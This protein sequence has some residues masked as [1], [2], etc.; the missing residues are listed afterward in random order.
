MGLTDG[1]KVRLYPS[2]GIA[3]DVQIQNNIASVASAIEA[4][5]ETISLG[6][7]QSFYASSGS[8]GAI[9]EFTMFYS[10]CCD[11]RLCTFVAFVGD[12]TGHDRE[13]T[14]DYSDVLSPSE[15]DELLASWRPGVDIKYGY[16]ARLQQLIASV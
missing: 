6:L 15:L 11:S 3:K 5:A 12:H 14:S 1:M 16:S 10:S 9:A 4:P 8:L 7:V 2:Y 13:L